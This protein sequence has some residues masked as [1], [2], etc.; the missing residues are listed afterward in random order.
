MTTS[1]VAF[2]VSSLRSAELSQFLTRF[3]DDLGKSGLDYASDD[4]LVRL[5]QDIRDKLPNLQSSL[6]Q[7]R[8]SSKTLSLSEA[9]NL[10]DSDIQALQAG[11]TPYRASK[12]PAEQSA[13]REL[14]A[15]FSTYK[16]IS[17]A[18]YEEETALVTSLLEKLSA[19][20][21]QE[22]VTELGLT[23]FVTNLRESQQAFNDLFGS[24]SE[25][26]LKQV[27]YDTKALR[28]AILKPY[29]DLSDYVSI[30]SRVKSDQLYTDFLGVLNNSRKYYADMK[31]RQ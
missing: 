9:D 26:R 17:R 6:E 21:Y 31:A 14:K 18:N 11:I 23:K 3:L 24:R 13:Y 1:L 27:S 29:Q 19:S 28:Q 15:L 8:S 5:T 7:V 30:L 22:A 2:R 20:P 10:R 25:D 16:G 4:V 12:R